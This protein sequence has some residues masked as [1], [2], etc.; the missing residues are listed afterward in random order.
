MRWVDSITNAM[1]MN[2]GKLW[3][4]V[5]DRDGWCPASP[6][7]CKESDTTGQL[8][9]NNN[10]NLHTVHN[11]NTAFQLIMVQHVYDSC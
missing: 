7:G 6:W 8:D 1:D 3:E 9:D 5:V 11:G 2:L 4:L 10:N